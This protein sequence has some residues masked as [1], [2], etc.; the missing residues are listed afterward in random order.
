MFLALHTKRP[1]KAL[2]PTMMVMTML[3]LKVE[4]LVARKLAT[5]A[6]AMKVEGVVVRRSAGVS[7]TLVGAEVA[8]MELAMQARM[9]ART[10]VMAVAMMRIMKPSPWAMMMSAALET[11]MEAD[12]M[13]PMRAL[14]KAV[15]LVAV[16]V[17]P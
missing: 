2:L 5:T 16:V 13:S 9:V 7:Q 17:D 12:T 15:V 6:E 3:I 8:S 11:P 4:G 10:P 14:G 1:S